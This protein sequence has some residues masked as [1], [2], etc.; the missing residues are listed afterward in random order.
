M[1]YSIG[2]LLAGSVRKLQLNNSSGALGQVGC[3]AE[4]EIS[5]TSDRETARRNRILFNANYPMISMLNRIV[6][7]EYTSNTQCTKDEDDGER[8]TYTHS[9]N[10]Y[11]RILEFLVQS[12]Q[13]EPC[14]GQLQ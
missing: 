12:V 6:Y 8:M 9:I 5:D 13:H 3:R 11:D 7:S 2:G 1:C 4:C 10:E 14:Y